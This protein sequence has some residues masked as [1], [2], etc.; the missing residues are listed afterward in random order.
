QIRGAALRCRPAPTTHRLL[1]GDH[2]LI[3]AR[4]LTASV[5]SAEGGPLAYFRGRYRQLGWGRARLPWRPR[6]RDRS[7]GES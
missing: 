5:P 6:T 3:V 1:A 7:T 2:T 4:V